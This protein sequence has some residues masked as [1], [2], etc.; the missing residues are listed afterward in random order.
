MAGADERLWF[1]LVPVL[2]PQK[3]HGQGPRRHVSRLRRYRAPRVLGQCCALAV[4]G[5][6]G[7]GGAG[8]C[9]WVENPVKAAGAALQEGIRAQPLAI[10]SL[11][12]ALS[13]WYFRWAVRVDTAER[14]GC[15]PPPLARGISLTPRGVGTSR[16]EARGARAAGQARS[17]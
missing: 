1:Y 11:L 2:P 5:G 3:A 13:S 14:F 4:T 9:P 17:E 15:S 6:V 8:V 12:N 16:I 10:Q 7:C